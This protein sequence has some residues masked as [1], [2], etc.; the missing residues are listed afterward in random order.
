M[1]RYNKN[2]LKAEIVRNGMNVERIGKQLGMSRPTVY[3][4]FNAGT[5]TL[6]DVK[7]IAELLNLS[8]K[9]VNRIFF[10]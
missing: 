8:G 4:R 10:A 7:K 9:D 2:E 6:D 1:L 5:W 3:K